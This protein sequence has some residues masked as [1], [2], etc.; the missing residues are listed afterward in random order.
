MDMAAARVTCA[1]LFLGFGFLLVTAFANAQALEDCLACHDDIEYSSTAHPDV[2]CGECHTNI[3][4]KRHK[5]GVEP[6]TDEDSC[7]N[8]HGR[9][10]RTI[11]RSIHDGQAAC[12]DCHGDPHAIRKVEEADCKVSAV[13]QIGQCGACHDTPETPL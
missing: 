13:N 3:V 4:D 10:V 9:T 6:L 2:A 1:K 12:I 5:R 8:C 7:G 11:G